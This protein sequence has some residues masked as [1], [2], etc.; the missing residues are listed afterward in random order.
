MLASRLAAV[1]A[2]VVVACG[3]TGGGSPSTSVGTTG[4]GSDSGE[5]TGTT[6]VPSTSGGGGECSPFEG[7]PFGA[8]LSAQS[9]V[10]AEDIDGL[11]VQ[12]VVYPLP[13]HR[14]KPWTSW[15]QGLALAD[16]RFFS[17][18]GDHFG[19]EG[20]SYVYEFDPNSGS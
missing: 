10:L 16:G 15:G 13:D 19:A 20:N 17:A 18:V 11:K 14:G 5:T 12:A 1:L 2:V 6:S 4:Q 7:E 3:T 9:V 8:V